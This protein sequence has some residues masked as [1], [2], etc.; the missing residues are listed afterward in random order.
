MQI[1]ENERKIERATKGREEQKKELIQQIRC[2][3]VG[4][5]LEVNEIWHHCPEYPASISEM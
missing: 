5:D 4:S 1:R 3:P 2:L